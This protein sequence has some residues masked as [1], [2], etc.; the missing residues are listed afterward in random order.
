MKA[1]FEKLIVSVIVLA[2]SLA[3]GVANADLVAHWGLDGNANDSIGSSDGTVIG[4]PNWDTGRFGGAL[5]F[6][7]DDYVML[8]N[9][10]HF[11]I[12]DEITV[13]AWIKVA[14]FD[15]QWQS[16]ITK[17]DDSWRLARN[18]TNNNL[19][20][21]CTGLTVDSSQWGVEGDVNVNDHRWHHV[22]GVYDGAGIHLYVDGVLDRSRKASGKIAKDDYKV[23]IGANAQKLQREWNG[24]IDDVVVFDHAL[25]EEEIVRLYRLG[26]VSF[27]SEPT[28]L[29][30]FNAV[31][32]AE[33]IVK[34]QRAQ[35]AITFLKKTI[36]EYEQWKQK[37]PN[38]IRL[39]HKVL[40]CDLYSL[41]AEAKEAAG[42]PKADV[43]D[44]YRRATESGMLSA[45]RQG[46][47]LLWL[48]ENTNAD[49]YGDIVEPFIQSSS[50][51]LKQVAAQ[52]EMMVREQRSKAA[53][54]FL[55]GNLAAHA[56]WR[57]KH[58]FDEVVAEDML[59]EIYLQLAKA[60]ETVGAPMK[61]V[62][63]AYSNTFSP[64]RF[65]Y[66][67][68]RVAALTW[69]VENE[70]TDECVKA[71]E[72]FTQD[73]DTR[74][75]FKNAVTQVCE[76]FESEKDWTKFQWF[77]DTLFSEAEYPYDWVVFVE[78]CLGNKTN[79]WAKSYYAYLDSKPRLAFGRDCIIA[80]K[81]VAEEK[82]AKAAE[83][84]QDIVNR[85]GPDDDKGAFEFQLCRCLFYGGKYREAVAKLE[86][87]IANNKATHR[88]LVKEAMLM[89]GRAHVQLS[90]IDKAIDVFFA[91]MI[92]YPET[93]EAPET[94]FFVGYCY[95][96]QG[97]FDQAT[98]AFDLVAQDYPSSSYA[99]KARMCLIRIEKMTQ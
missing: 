77:L 88:S 25:K 18:G 85:C 28:F 20:F 15:K 79:R 87:F 52:A 80:E 60:K 40:S 84:Y 94:N 3:A 27:T 90:E 7:G 76:H 38:A 31:L 71:I 96:L 62:A 11:D 17:G 22:A 56:R 29:M 95:M 72:S 24:L 44:T 13:A 74:A 33:T 73:R 98:A 10:S 83:L 6:D 64:S 97:K 70:R 12:T 23:Y 36:A 43:A 75:C 37:D 91:V 19:A 59:P 9:E 35:E 93:K 41:L 55:E 63:D 47:T 99:S 67:P 68:E 58:P 86:S 66:I 57:E 54:K 81:H 39:T 4:Y 5:L 21:H 8:P 92:E 26:G 49:E 16:I 78:S 14:A 30:L 89:K 82:F 48:Y 61:D 42:A 46:L 45:P 32:K 1:K 69:L 51:Y 50:N 53:I 34:E 2:M 65:D